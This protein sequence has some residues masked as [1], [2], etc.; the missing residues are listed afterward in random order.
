MHRAWA[1][2]DGGVVVA[3]VSSKFFGSVENSF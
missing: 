2:I 1:S 3:D